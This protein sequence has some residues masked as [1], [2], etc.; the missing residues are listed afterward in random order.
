MNLLTRG[1]QN[2]Q[3]N[4][5]KQPQYFF[6]SCLIGFP[7]CL[8]E[9]GVT[10]SLSFLLGVRGNPQAKHATCVVRTLFICWRNEENKRV[11]LKAKKKQKQKNPE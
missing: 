9:I 5:P 10:I 1:Y 3:L 4:S 11:S 2:K 6:L 8:N 7:F